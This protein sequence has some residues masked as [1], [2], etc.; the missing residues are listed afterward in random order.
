MTPT[1]RVPGRVLAWAALLVALGASVGANVAFARPEIGP[2][3]SAA[4]APVLVVLAAGLLERVPL[5]SARAWQRRLAGGGLVF[6]VVSAF[7]TSYQHQHELLIGYGNP[8]TSA[9]LLPLAVDA[10]ILMA[11]VS[12]AVIAERRRAL[13]AVP[14]ASPAVAGVSDSV[15]DTGTAP[16]QPKRQVARA[17]KKPTTADRVAAAKRRT[18]DA[19]AADIARRVGVTERTVQRYLP[20]TE[21]PAEFTD[22]VSDTHP[23]NGARVTVDA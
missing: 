17:A 10:L 8:E 18:P 12:L 23:H 11:S 3:L 7:V 13:A 2:R 14:A 1:T 21:L 9:T 4:T 20:R 15:S 22:A 19:S 6:V 16:E 5:T